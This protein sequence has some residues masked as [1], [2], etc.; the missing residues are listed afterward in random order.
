MV[1]TVIPM[2]NPISIKKIGKLTPIAPTA[3]SPTKCPTHIVLMM[4]Y[5][6]CIKFPI[7]IGMEKYKRCLGMLPTVKSVPNLLF[8]SSPPPP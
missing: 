4:L 7:S 3:F 1:A 6:I 5:P 8:I 2:A